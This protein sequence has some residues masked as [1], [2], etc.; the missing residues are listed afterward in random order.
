MWNKIVLCRGDF[1]KRGLCD[2]YLHYDLSILTIQNAFEDSKSES[3]QPIDEHNFIQLT[4]FLP[5][6]VLSLLKDFLSEFRIGFDD[7]WHSFC[8][9]CFL[10]HYFY[11]CKNEKGDNAESVNGHYDWSTSR[12]LLRLLRLICCGSEVWSR[13]SWNHRTTRLFK[14]YSNETQIDEIS[15]LKASYSSLNISRRQTSR[16]T[17]S[18]NN[19]H[20]RMWWNCSSTLQHSRMWHSV[21]Q[22][23][24]SFLFL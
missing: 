19:W 1:S 7:S 10:E 15:C 23:W 5:A 4:Q 6:L 16:T 8:F 22:M 17:R 13:L 24:R 21:S 20:S 9:V 11:Y 12:L 2:S 3:F 14:K 18:L